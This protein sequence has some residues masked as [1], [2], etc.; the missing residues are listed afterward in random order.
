[1]TLL[2][3]G[4][5]GPFGNPHSNNSPVFIF[6]GDS[7]DADGWP[8]L[9]SPFPKYLGGTPVSVFNV[10]LPSQTVGPRDPA[11]PGPPGMIETAWA[12]LA[13]LID[14]YS[15]CVWVHF[16]GGI[17][18]V[19]TSRSVG[20][21]YSSIR[22]WA[23]MVRRWGIRVCGRTLTSHYGLQIDGTPVDSARIAVNN[24]LRANAAAI[25]DAFNDLGQTAPQLDAAGAYSN[26]N[27]YYDGV[28]PTPAGD[29]MLANGTGPIIAAALSS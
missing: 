14:V 20:Y 5:A 2:T 17:D 25:F 22:A 15:G 24:L 16:G 11:Y 29:Q 26:T 28:H 10:S 27:L 6:K 12:D 9:I 7:I 8:A 18:D 21:T 13:P 19:G 1:M 3:L 4:P 23:A